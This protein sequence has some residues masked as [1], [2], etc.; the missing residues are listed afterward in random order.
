MHEYGT[1]CGGFGLAVYHV[2]GLMVLRTL[3]SRNPTMKALFLELSQLDALASTFF[4]FSL[5]HRILTYYTGYHHMLLESLAIQETLIKHQNGSRG[6]LETLQNVA[7]QLLAT[8]ARVGKGLH[9]PATEQVQRTGHVLVFQS[10]VPLSG[11]Y[12]MHVLWNLNV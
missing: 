5:L 12:Q 8:I 1:F 2:F 9:P 3:K 4:G 6:S 10:A 7:S 11:R